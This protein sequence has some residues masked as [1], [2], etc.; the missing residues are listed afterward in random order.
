MVKN[1]PAV[2]QWKWK[3]LSHV[4]LFERVHGIFQARILVWVAFPFSR[5]LPNPR[6]KSRSPE[7]QADSLPAEPQGK[8]LVLE[9]PVQFPGLG[10]SPGGGHGKSLQYSCQENPHGKRSLA[11]YSPWIHKESD[12]TERLTFSLLRVWTVEYDYLISSSKTYYH[13]IHVGNYLHSL[14][15]FSY[16]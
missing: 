8:P 11:G 4:R 5:G 16:F 14:Y 3:S 6:I 2:Q 10:R 13:S 9:M 15:L 7:L 12:M 1:L